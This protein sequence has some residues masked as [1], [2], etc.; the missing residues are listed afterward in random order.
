MLSVCY[1]LLS[2]FLNLKPVPLLEQ[3][4]LALFELFLYVAFFLEN[5]GSGACEFSLKGDFAPRFLPK[6]LISIL[7]TL[8]VGVFG[9]QLSWIP[10]LFIW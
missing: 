1:W 5:S 3:V 4:F 8:G 7:V 10:M 6:R 9:W 2:G